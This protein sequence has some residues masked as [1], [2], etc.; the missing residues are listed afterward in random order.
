MRRGRGSYS[1][2]LGAT[3]RKLSGK[4]LRARALE[5]PARG[6]PPQSRRQ[7]FLLLDGPARA[8]GQKL[9]RR[10]GACYRHRMPVVQL[11]R[12]ESPLRAT[13]EERLPAAPFLKW[14]GGKGSLLAELIKHVPAR[15]S[16]RRYHEPFVGGGAL[17]FAVAPRRASLFHN[18]LCLTAI[19]SWNHPFPFRTGP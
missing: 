7:D 8:A 9:H 11:R 6:H 15:S 12:D 18:Q 16:L 5:N 1:N 3:T 14:V 4:H 2:S 10:I 19:A 13:P 17:F